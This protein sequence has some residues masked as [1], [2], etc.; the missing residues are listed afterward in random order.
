MREAGLISGSESD[1]SLWSS[2]REPLSPKSGAS[3]R[4]K[5]RQKLGLTDES[6][7]LSVVEDTAPLHGENKATPEVSSKSGKQQQSSSRK[8]HSY[9]KGLG[10]NGTTFDYSAARDKIPG[11]SLSLEEKSRDGR[12]G[13]RGT[14]LGNFAHRRFRAW[15]LAYKRA[16]QANKTCFLIMRGSLIG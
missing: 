4:A 14:S 16:I 9:M 7:F 1:K 8:G 11:L 5:K 15:I 10:E 12:G 3:G 13:R 6:G 2:E